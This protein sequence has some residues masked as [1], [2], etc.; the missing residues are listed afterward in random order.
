MAERAP[1]KKTS[2]LRAPDPPRRH[3]ARAARPTRKAQMEDR[4]R[5]QTAQG[6][7]RPRPLRRPL[8]ARVVPPHRPS[9]RRAR[10]PHART[11]TP[12][13]PAAGLTLPRAVRLLEPLF[14][15]WTG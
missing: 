12:F 6:R 8:L 4:A 9:H 11:A 7:T 3:R 1:P 10:I 14:K 13:S 5:L 15:C 2:G